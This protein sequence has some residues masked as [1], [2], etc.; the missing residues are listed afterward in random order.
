[1]AS[2]NPEDKSF[3][4]DD[5]TKWPSFKPN[6]YYQMCVVFMGNELTSEDCLGYGSGDGSFGYSF[7]RVYK[8]DSYSQIL[9]GIAYNADYRFW[10]AVVKEKTLIGAVFSR[11]SGWLHVVKGNLKIGQSQSPNGGEGVELGESIN[12]RG[13]YVNR[14]LYG[15]GSTNWAARFKSE[16]D[17]INNGRQDY[18]SYKFIPLESCPGGT[19]NTPIFNQLPLSSP[20]LIIYSGVSSPPPPPPKNMNCCDYNTIATIIE[21]QMMARDKLFENL[22]DHIDQRIKEEI[23]IHGKQL[24]ALEVD[25]QPV[26]DR[27]NESE[28]NLWNGKR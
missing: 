12:S 20:S 24:E 11:Q 9:I 10:D 28:S 2:I 16:L 19:A 7:K 5:P 17:D 21:S 25:L 27:I 3:G 15:I 22:K 13:G 6:C 1:M 18:T 23:T 14:R 8:I 26:I 4:A